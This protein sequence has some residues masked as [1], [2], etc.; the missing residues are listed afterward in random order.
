MYAYGGVLATA[1]VCL[2]RQQHPVTAPSGPIG[3]FGAT[4]DGPEGA[5][6]FLLAAST[7]L[8]LEFDRQSATSGRSQRAD[9][10]IT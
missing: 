6:S 8:L 2:S 5:W 1:T 9:A 3:P 10:R 4:P 7:S